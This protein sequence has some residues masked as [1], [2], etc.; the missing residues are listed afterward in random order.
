MSNNHVIFER[1][2]IP[3]HIYLN[4]FN[5][6]N[7]ATESFNIPTHNSTNIPTHNSTNIPNYDPN[8]NNTSIRDN[9]IYLNP[10]YGYRSNPNTGTTSNININRQTNMQTNRQTSRQ[11]NRQTSRQTNVT[12]NN[13]NQIFNNLN[14]IN[15]QHTNPVN[16]TSNSNIIWDNYPY[17]PSYTRYYRQT[18]LPQ[19]RLHRP[20][21]GNGHDY[22]NIRNNYNPRDYDRNSN[23]VTNNNRRHYVDVRNIISNTTINSSSHD[24]PDNLNSS[25][26]QIRQGLLNNSENLENI[27]RQIYYTATPNNTTEYS[28]NTNDVDDDAGDDNN[29]NNNTPGT[30]STIRNENIRNNTVF[31]NLLR[32]VFNSGLGSYE[33][34]INLNRDLNEESNDDDVDNGLE[35]RDLDLS[36]KI[37]IYK[38]SEQSNVL[39]DSLNRND[40]ESREIELENN[41]YYSNEPKSCA[42]CFNNLNNNDICRQI[43]GCKHIFHDTCLN[44]WLYNHNTCPVCRLDLSANTNSNQVDNH[45][46]N[47]EHDEDSNSSDDT[48]EI[49]NTNSIIV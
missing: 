12:S 41:C 3:E 47:S 31:R 11:A 13:N 39:Y 14:L 24:N 43:N 30:G 44:R 37:L 5:I 4:S 15:R 36:T 21:V 19:A 9:S 42:I 35:I 28:Q 23:Q 38:N 16:N 18:R 34:V 49:N 46:E 8:F 29:N 6:S 22:R 25:H 27:I 45:N 2:Y 48:D 33:V 40:I 1:Y 20:N 17:F 10:L 32:N 7:N 26:Q